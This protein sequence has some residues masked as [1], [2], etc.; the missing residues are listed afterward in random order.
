MR[1]SK[2][3]FMRS[4]EPTALHHGYALTGYDNHRSGVLTSK[5]RA[6]RIP[7]ARREFDNQRQWQGAVQQWELAHQEA[8]TMHIIP[9]TALQRKVALRGAGEEEIAAW[10]AAPPLAQ[11]NWALHC[12]LHGLFGYSQDSD[13]ENGEQQHTQ[14]GEEDEQYTLVETDTVVETKHWEV[15]GL[16]PG[17]SSREVTMA[18]R[19]LSRQHHPDKA[20]NSEEA[21]RV[22]GE[23]AAAN[24]AIQSSL[25]TDLE[26]GEFL[27]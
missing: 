2:F 13:E 21:N 1:R 9:P 25:D 7:P 26:I 12:G 19:T 16:Q 18:Y 8:K 14:V 5:Q 22:M 20:G 6:R 11:R 10:Y 3:D 23:L 17:A 27:D 24:A 4:F 15:L